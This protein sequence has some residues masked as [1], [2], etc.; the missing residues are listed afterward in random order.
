MLFS[1]DPKAGNCAGREPMPAYAFMCARCKKTFDVVLTVAA[2]AAA[3]V[4]CP[5]CGG[6]EITP[7]MAIFTANTSRKS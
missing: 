1:R 5:T 4:A 3:K 7:E 2:R 6:G